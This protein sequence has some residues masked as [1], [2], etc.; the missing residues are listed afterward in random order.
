[1]GTTGTKGV[2][3]ADR[4]RQ[5]I[6][7]AV[8]EIGRRGYA[9]TSMAEI[10]HRAGVSKAMVHNIFGN[11]VELA[12]A[13]LEEV[14]PPLVASV[15]AAQTSTEAGRRAQET[16]TAIFAALVEHRHAWALVHD[17]TLPQGSSAEQAAT[18]YLDQLHAMGTAGTRD[19]LEAAG[20]EDPLDHDLLDH[21]WEAVVATSVYWWQEHEEL[22][23]DA[24]A[25]RLTRLLTAVTVRG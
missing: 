8:A 22:S 6:A 9:T 3:R 1:M 23:A 21:I 20:L 17:A 4:R 12:R 7:V 16:F 25:Q 14:G 19:V 18:G 2:A 10:A 11:K 15:A 13:C 24:M 5:L